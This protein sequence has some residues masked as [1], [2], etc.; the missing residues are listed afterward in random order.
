[1]GSLD[2]SVHVEALFAFPLQNFSFYGQ[3]KKNDKTKI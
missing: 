3:P 2:D 1:M